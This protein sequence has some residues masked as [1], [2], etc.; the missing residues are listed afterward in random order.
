MDIECAKYIT[1]EIKTDVPSAV[2]TS[3]KSIKST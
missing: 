1:E 2:G 3:Q